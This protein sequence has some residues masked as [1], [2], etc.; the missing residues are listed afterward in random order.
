MTILKRNLLS[1]YEILSEI[2]NIQEEHFISLNNRF[3]FEVDNLEC[4][5]VIINPALA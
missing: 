4:K 3:D 2:R 5:K 1:Y